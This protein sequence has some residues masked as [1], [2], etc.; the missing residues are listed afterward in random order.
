MNHENIEKK[1]LKSLKTNNLEFLVKELPQESIIVGGY[2]RDLILG[3]RNQLLDID[4]VV[5][6]NALEICKKNLKKI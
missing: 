3:N 1:I 2:I 4:I 5:P 6:E